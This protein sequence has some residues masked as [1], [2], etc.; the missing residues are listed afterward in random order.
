MSLTD[1]SITTRSARS[2]LS[3]GLEILKTVM[4]CLLCQ[5]RSLSPGIENCTES[6][7]QEIPDLSN[8]HDF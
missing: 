4:H 2:H 5:L 6:L 8:V 7:I 3:S 1:I